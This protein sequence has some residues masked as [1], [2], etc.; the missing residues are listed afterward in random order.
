MPPYNTRATSTEARQQQSLEQLLEYQKALKHMLEELPEAGKTLMALL[1]AQV[2]GAFRNHPLPIALDAVHYEESI[3]LTLLSGTTLVDL[4]HPTPRLLTGLFNN[5]P[6]GGQ[7]L[8]APNRLYRYSTKAILSEVNPAA[9]GRKR[10]IHLTTVSTPAFEHFMS[11]L[12]RR[13]DRCFAQQLEVFWREAST[14]GSSLSRER[15]LAEQLGKAVAA[16]AALR[17]ADQTLDARDKALIDQV[18]SHPSNRARG[19]LP[20]QQ[21]PAALSVYLKGQQ[22]DADIALAGIFIISSKTPATDISS[23]TD[24]GSVV[25]FTPDK[26]IDAFA[27]MRDL[28][29]ALRSRF[30]TATLGDSLLGAISWQDQARAKGYQTASPAFGYTQ[31]EENLFDI[32][33]QSLLT[34]QK[35]DI[36]HGWSLLPRHEVDGKQVYELLNR[37]AHIGSFLDIRDRLMDRSRR[38][39][40]ANLPSWYQDASPGDK[41]ALDRLIEAEL[42]S[43]KALVTQFK[44]IAIPTLP[45]FARNELIRQLTIDHPDIPIDPDQVTVEITHGINPASLGGGIGPDHVPHIGD[46]ATRPSHI[47]TLSLTELALRNIDPWNFSFYKIFT[48][49]KT[50][51]LARGKEPSGKPVEFDESYLRSLVQ[52]LDV[53]A[54]YDQLLQTQLLTNASALRRA[55]TDAHRASLACAALVARLDSGSLL[56]GSEHRDHQWI[57]AIVEAD[58]P[59]SRKTVNGHRIVASSLLIANSASTRNGY[60]LNEVMMISV[61]NRQSL[62]NVILYTPGAPG[63]QTFKEF[64]DLE[65]MQLFL[66]Q[67]WAASPDWQ[68]YVMQRLSRPGQAALTER[69]ASRIALIG[70][71]LLNARSRVGNPFQTIYAFA[72]NAPLHDALYEQR[73]WT[74]RRNADHDSTSNAEVEEQSLW[75]KIAFGLDLALNLVELLPIATTFKTIRSVTKVFLLLKQ[76]GA[77]KSAAR[78]L[79]SI[80]GPKIHPRLVP[81]LGALPALRPAPDLA[82]LEVQVRTTELNRIKGNLYQSKTGAQQYAL[83]DGKYYL[84]D[85][86]QG[87]RFIYPPGI[88][89]KTLRY[90][91]SEDA[92]LPDWQVEPLP[93]LRGGMYALER[94]PFETTY[95]DYELSLADRASLPALNVAPSGAFGLG[96][97]S[98]ALPKSA[99]TGVLHLFAIQTRLRRHAR[100]FFQTFNSPRGSLMMP[101]RDLLPEQ[102]FSHLFNQR[103]GLVIGENHSHDLTRRM[104]I[105]NMP[106]LKR[107]GLRNLYLEQLSTD[108]HQE[109]L[110][111]FN[112]SPTTPL[113][114]PL[115]ERLQRMDSRFSAASPHSYTH[116]VEAAHAQGV[117]IMALDTTA[118]AQLTPSALTAPGAALRLSDQLD[119]VTMFNFFAYKKIAFDQMA[120]G[121]HRWLAL[122]G[123][124]HCSTIQGIPG[125]AELTGAA[126]IRMSSRP[127]TMP[128]RIGR[129]PGVMLPSPLDTHRMLLKCDVLIYMADPHLSLSVAARVHS[130]NLFMIIS[131]PPG[132]IFVHY[133]NAQ[134]Q[135]VDVPVFTEDTHIYVDHAEFAALSNRRFNN[136]TALADALID[137]LQM[138]EV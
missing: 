135:H 70:E 78:A 97:L 87:N 94:D 29:Q 113:P 104:L 60:V 24:I 132:N 105:E 63:G 123:N 88:A 101:P 14:A 80:S 138:V 115:R 126:S 84:S 35:Q 89:S 9:P 118:S 65:A 30:A 37:L 64:A 134:Y 44:S 86:A 116:L 67:K 128:L 77:S 122:V 19:H 108:H 42:E 32:L 16:E 1:H 107:Q 133:M 36:A 23:S 71:L 50:S 85:V 45:V 46:P 20:V 124:G 62:P 11:E 98:P 69:K 83:I 110:D 117:Q 17:V 55:W 15:W 121:P 137:V 43:N 10:T 38:Y 5:T 27:S 81:R 61:E 40:E 136:L 34:L 96:I 49:E 100:R 103:N 58:T 31:I 33:V 53:S 66:K 54:G 130:P 76:A 18:V 52:R 120:H 74:L 13:P 41:Q 12:I 47:T 28:D 2:Q 127:H 72:I 7:D 48:G 119:R 51:M 90:P 57:Q 106:A 39:I 73:V 93:R 129:D 6:W 22:Q 25:L 109:L 26:G 75:N 131:P 56:P 111:T 114:L 91:L 99:W 3:S 59:A 68:R 92:T 102:L 4:P 82:G 79:W 112:A 125:L 95:K 8:D 21:R